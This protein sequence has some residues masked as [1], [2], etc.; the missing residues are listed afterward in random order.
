LGVI[1]DATGHVTELCLFNASLTDTLH[2]IYSPAFQSI[3]KL[4]LD[5]NLTGAIPTNLSLFFSTV[6]A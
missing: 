6:L 3:N 1:C 5:Y 4:Y 2:G